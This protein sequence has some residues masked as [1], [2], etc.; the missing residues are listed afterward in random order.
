MLRSPQAAVEDSAV[1]V[2]KGPS[3]VETGNGGVVGLPGVKL[4][5][6]PDPKAGATFQ[7]DKDHPLK[8]EKGLQVMFVVSK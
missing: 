7:A 3:S 8:L 2:F 4:T 1:T 5:V 6:S